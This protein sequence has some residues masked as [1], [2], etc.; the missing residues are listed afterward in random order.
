M[1]RNELATWKEMVEGGHIL[2]TITF[3]Y[4]RKGNVTFSSALSIE[5]AYSEEIGQFIDSEVKETWVCGGRKYTRYRGADAKAEYLEKLPNRIA[6]I[7]AR[8][9]LRD[10]QPWS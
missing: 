2:R 10:E 5:H 6:A 9:M 3:N 8:K 4:V 1:K 7:Q